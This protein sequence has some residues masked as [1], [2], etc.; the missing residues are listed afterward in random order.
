MSEAEKPDD[1][2]LVAFGARTPVGLNVL[3]AAAAVRAGIAGFGE[4]PYMADRFGKAMIVAMDPGIG[5]EIEGPDRL[6]S[7]LL[8]ALT[9]V[10]AALEGKVPPNTPLPMILSLPPARPEAD[11]GL[12]KLLTD[13]LLRDAP[14][15][16]KPASVG[17]FQVGHGGGLLALEDACRRLKSGACELCLV[18]GVDSW[19]ADET[20]EALDEAEQL[21]SE[22]HPW[23][24]IP[25]EAAGA[26][27]VATR[28]AADR[29][30]LD[31]LGTV[32][33]T[34]V[35]REEHLIHTDTVCV[36]RGLTEAMRKALKPLESSGEK[37]DQTYCD[38]N[39]QPYRSHEFGYT[40]TRVNRQFVNSTDFEAPADCWGD[41]RAATG[42]LLLMLAA[43]AGR[44]G[45]SHGARIL[46]WS[47]SDGGERAAALVRVPAVS[48]E[49]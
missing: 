45:Y 2:C 29:M 30:K 16:V 46:V 12:A 42:P 3:S 49:A 43:V 15:A 6:G 26:F 20:L 25:G 9:E 31:I 8:A 21:K 36:G 22:K 17:T 41:V 38:F 13:R 4:H 35:A 39:G 27:V 37:V 7:L 34:G 1:V 28:R 40:V 10:A 5:E 44:K 18:A 32:T 23:G 33:A 24:F 11:G 47:S 48:Q 14:A 19:L